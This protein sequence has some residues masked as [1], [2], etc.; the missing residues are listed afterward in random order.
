MV[1]RD[2]PVRGNGSVDCSYLSARIQ[3][4]GVVVLGRPVCRE[5]REGLVGA[6]GREGAHFFGAGGGRAESL[7][8]PLG[9]GD[10]SRPRGRRR[11]PLDHRE[12][13]AGRLVGA[14]ARLDVEVVFQRGRQPFRIEARGAQGLL[15]QHEVLK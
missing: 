11:R 1:K 7:R 4:R 2:S 6:D 10:A 12:R 8:S 9:T 14:A 5:R 13:L 15:V 3:R